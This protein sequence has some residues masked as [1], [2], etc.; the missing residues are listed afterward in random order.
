M[1]ITKLQL[2]QIIKEEISKILNENKGKFTYSI[3]EDSSEVDIQGIDKTFE[4]MIGELVGKEV[5]VDGEKFIVSLEPFG[6]TAEGLANA[7]HAGTYI[8][9]WAEMNGW[10]AERT[11]GY[12]Q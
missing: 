3:Y 6:G 7:G 9:L 4:E 11:G 2:K 5:N 8:E 10:T 12:Y 1:K